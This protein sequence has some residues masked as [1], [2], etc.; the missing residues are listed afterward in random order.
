MK[1]RRLT[2]IVM[3]MA[4]MIIPFDSVNAGQT[5]NAGLQAA[6]AVTDGMQ[7][8]RCVVPVQSNIR[9]QASTLSSLNQYTTVSQAADIA[10]EKLVNHESVISI[11]IKSENSSPVE[12]FA[13]FE[14]ELMK[15]TDRGDEGDY[16]YWDINREYPS[17]TYRPVKKGKTTYYYYVFRVEY[18]F[19]TT[20][21]QK[22][23]VDAKV[24]EII[25]SFN[26]TS[27][28]TDYE[29]IYA[30]YD[31][32]CKN[33]KYAEDVEQDIV[34]TSWSALFNHEAVC[35]GYSQLMY[36]IL[37]E[38]GISARV[39]PGYGFDTSVFHGW[40]IV[41]VGDYYY[42]LDATWDSENYLS[43]TSYEYFLKGDTFRYHTRLADYASAE[44]YTQYPMAANDYGTGTPTLSV[45]SQKSS[46]SMIKPKFK[47]VSRKKIT[48]IK[49]AGRK[50]YQISYSTTK[51]FKKNTKTVTTKKTTYKLKNLD[52]NQKYY[53]KFRAY[54]KIDGERVYTQW[55]N[56]KK[57]KKVSNK[58]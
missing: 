3:A 28:T 8:G 45:T 31:Y 22:Y 1:L 24:K 30:V 25:S 44:F 10:R 35:Q 19:F 20:L 27:E 18:I 32:V 17:Y 43:G 5:E 41:K 38:M 4:L 7:I 6:A 13:E 21:E 14:N 51:K 49:V 56:V 47:K 12:V 57:I 29:K 23:Q 58:K 54:K 16:M 46:F 55:S 48:L 39:I 52:K 15:E 40:N 53:V 26:F 34:Y 33:V 42:N 9:L 37:K 50:K 2:A 36:R 11:Y